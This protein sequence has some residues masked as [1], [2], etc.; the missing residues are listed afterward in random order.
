LLLV[1]IK[2]G[3][4]QKTIR[5]LPAEHLFTMVMGSLRLLVLQWQVSGYGFDLMRAG[6]KL[7]LSLETLIKKTKGC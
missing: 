2:S 3:Q 7:W 4:R 5:V 6:E 1:T